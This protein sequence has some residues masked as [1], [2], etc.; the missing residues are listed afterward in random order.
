MSMR[1]HHGRQIASQN[2]LS[3]RCLLFARIASVSKGMG[4]GACGGE[5]AEH[6]LH[7]RQGFAPQALR[8]AG[9]VYG[10][11]VLF[12]RFRGVESTRS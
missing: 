12:D 10:L 7:R 2:R 8:R 5:P 3:V 4:G 6:R 11:N 1:Q 9:V